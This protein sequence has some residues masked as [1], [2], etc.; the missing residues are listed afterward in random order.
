MLALVLQQVAKRDWELAI[1]GIANL[2]AAFELSALLFSEALEQRMKLGNEGRDL[3]A[4]VAPVNRTW[5]RD[6][7]DLTKQLKLL[8]LGAGGDGLLEPFV[9]KICSLPDVG[10]GSG[11][12]VEVLGVVLI[13]WRLTL[14]LNERVER[15]QRTRGRALLQIKR[16]LA[17]ELWFSGCQLR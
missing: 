7:L 5:E 9:V 4:C 3:P 15:G 10:G 13:Q 8:I 14:A 11:G 1:D 16:E 2:L 17:V 6:G 12:E